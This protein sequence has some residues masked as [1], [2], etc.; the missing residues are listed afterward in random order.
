MRYGLWGGRLDVG[1]R[2]ELTGA[3][4]WRAQAIT[5]RDSMMHPDT[6]EVIPVMMRRCFYLPSNLPIFLGM[7]L[8]P[9]TVGWISTWQIINNGYS[10]WMNYCNRNASSSQSGLQ[11]LGSLSVAIGLSTTIAVRVRMLMDKLAHRPWAA[12]VW[13]RA[14]TQAVVPF[15]AMATSGSINLIMARYGEA[16]DGI[17]VRDEHGNSVGRSVAAGR[18]AVGQTVASRVLMPLLPASI[19]PLIMHGLQKYKPHTVAKFG[20]MVVIKTAVVSAVCLLALPFSLAPFPYCVEKDVADL[21]PEF[22]NL[23]SSVTGLPLTKVYY[24][25]GL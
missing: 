17:E 19:P 4:L 22:A 14:L 11:M 16:L 13:G 18:D 8:S 21:E 1:L 23:R 6:G 15:V 25:R 9:Q 2:G 24:N 7:L 10:T 20:R 3:C 5:T 12:T